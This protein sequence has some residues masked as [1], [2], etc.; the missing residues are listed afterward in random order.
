MNFT[1]IESLK[2][3]SDD[4]FEEKFSEVIS[5]MNSVME[6]AAKKGLLNCEF[7]EAELKAFGVDLPTIRTHLN[8]EG[9]SFYTGWRENENARWYHRFLDKE[10]YNIR[11]IIVSWGYLRKR[12]A[13][14]Y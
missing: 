11:L 1:S 6:S 13:G 14:Q 12:Q 8:N 2:K 7:T 3:M 10:N 5:Y 4:V 9:Y